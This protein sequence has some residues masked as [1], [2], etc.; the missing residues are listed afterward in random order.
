MYS[1]NQDVLLA[2]SAARK[3]DIEAAERHLNDSQVHIDAIV[4][5][6]RLH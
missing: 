3:G 1:K 4:S 5:C 2:I 6:Y